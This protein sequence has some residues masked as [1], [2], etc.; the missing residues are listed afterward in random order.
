MILQKLEGFWSC[1]KQL[2]KFIYLSIDK[3]PLSTS[4][5]QRI[6][7]SETKKKIIFLSWKVLKIVARNFECT[8]IFFL[9]I[10]F[11]GRQKNAGAYNKRNITA[12]WPLHCTMNN[13]GSKK[14]LLN[15]QYFDLAPNKF[16]DTIS[17]FI[18]F[19]GWLYYYYLNGHFWNKKC[20]Q[21][22]EIACRN[23]LLRY[24][25]SFIIFGA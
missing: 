25:S 8:A 16:A 20:S 6:S 10:P 17:I 4:L 7:N 5:G 18:S 14:W 12:S 1:K 11:E 9:Q 3:R 21:W 2:I 19:G 22:I 23:N 15:M 13:F 24:K